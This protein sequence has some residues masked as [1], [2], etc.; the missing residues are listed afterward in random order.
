M[1]SQRS[2]HNFDEDRQIINCH[3]INRARIVGITSEHHQAFVERST[4]S[5]KS[6]VALKQRPQTTMN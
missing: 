1:S 4:I 6:L 5:A 2:L 3:S